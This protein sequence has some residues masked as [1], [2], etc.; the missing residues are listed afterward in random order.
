MTPAQIDHFRQ[1]L[2]QLRA[3]ITHELDAM[4]VLGTDDDLRTGDQTDQA[5]AG[6]EREFQAMNRETA[7]MI[8]A[9]FALSGGSGVHTRKST[10]SADMMRKRG[11]NS[12]P[13]AR[14]ERERSSS[15]AK[16]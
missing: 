4:P 13:D 8:S 2:G 14:I 1:K 11:T 5:S 7:L 3:T 6:S 12:A 15:S 9:R 16:H 10:P